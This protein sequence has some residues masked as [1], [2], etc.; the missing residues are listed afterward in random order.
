MHTP[1][2][3][4]FMEGIEEVDEHDLQELKPVCVGLVGGR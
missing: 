2:E 3:L 4:L 1:W